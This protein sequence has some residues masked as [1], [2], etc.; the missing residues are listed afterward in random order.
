MSHVAFDSDPVYIEARDRYIEAQ[1]SKR[2]QPTQPGCGSS[3]TLQP[4]DLGLHVFALFLILAL[5]FGA[6]A[7]PV[8]AKRFPNLPIPR[9]ALFICRHFGTGVLLATAF[10]HLLPTAFISLTDACLS[11]FWNEGYPAM[12]GFIAMVSVF[13]VVGIE[14]FFASKGAAHTH[15][16][17]YTTVL[18]QGSQAGSAESVHQV[19]HRHP[20]RPRRNSMK[21]FKQGHIGPGT[22]T[23]DLP[24]ATSSSSKAA[25]QS[26]TSPGPAKSGPGMEMNDMD[27][28]ES[29][30]PPA[31]RP[32]SVSSSDSIPPAS[33]SSK[34]TEYQQQ[35]RALL[36]C[37][38]LEAG[39][40]FHSVFIGMAVS[41]ATG[42]AFVVLLIAISFHQTFE[43]LALGSRIAAITA[44]PQG[45]W[46]PWLMA[47]AY[48]MTT[49]IGQAIG[50]IVHNLY[51]PQSRT[52]LLMVGIMNAISSG[53][54]L[55]AGLVE[56][57]AEDFLSESSYDTLKGARRL[58]ASAA[59][60][61]GGM[62][63]ALVGAWA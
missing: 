61:A 35:Q 54:L 42:T 57:L 23:D 9:R 59:V 45:S 63:M 47:L 22:S 28:Q 52:G 8:V 53:L 16:S 44:F 55:F 51:D 36:Q 31:S 27:R 24:Q 20:S 29:I 6:C 15:S 49:P 46:K 18:Q 4:Y 40:L 12:A 58:E 38:L 41:V 2:Q 11:P 10:V 19:G 25:A 39:I 26:P 43:G 14:M 17:D 34:L 50:L 21:R 48:G 7:F 37:L 62:L 13:V 30:E 56:L 33:S 32:S 1:F 5:S 60:V 3:G